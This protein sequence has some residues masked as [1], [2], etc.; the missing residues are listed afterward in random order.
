[1]SVYLLGTPF[2]PPPAQ[3]E[4]CTPVRSTCLPRTS[5]CGKKKRSGEIISQLIQ[6]NPGAHPT[7]KAVLP[8]DTDWSHLG[9]Q[10][11]PARRSALVLPCPKSRSQ[12]MTVPHWLTQTLEQYTST[13]A[14]HRVCGSCQ[15]WT[16]PA[17]HQRLPG[18]RGKELEP[19][20]GRLETDRHQQTG[21]RCGNSVPG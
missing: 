18:S 14:E 7:S 16:L 13:L 8:I 6:T 2:P 17:A 20:L 15:G 3:V 21:E 11:G 1:M 12:W 4:R 5:V 10:A 19:K 9:G